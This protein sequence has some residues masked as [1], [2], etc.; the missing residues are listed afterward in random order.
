MSG[1]IYLIH[2]S[3]TDKVYVGS[4]ISPRQRKAAHFHNLRRGTHHSIHLQRAF[5]RH[6]E[7]AFYFEIVEN[8]EEECF[9]HAREQFWVWRFVDRLYN[10]GLITGAPIGIKR[11]QPVIDAIAK[12][13]KGNTFRRGHKMPP[14]WSEANSIRMTGNKHRLGKSHSD[15]DKAKIS[16][17]LKRATDEGRRPKAMNGLIKFREDIEAG[18]VQSP[19]VKQSRNDEMIAMLEGGNS[20]ADIARHFGLDPSG[21]RKTILNHIKRMNKNASL[22]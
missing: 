4:T 3:E 21:A 13:M 8:V 5:D 18:L 6:R 11:S 7:N 22:L 15:D 10:V 16:A 17:G 20:F 19:W 1:V 9:L 2:C 14:G 12:R